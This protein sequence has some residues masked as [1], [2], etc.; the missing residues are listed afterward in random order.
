MALREVLRDARAEG[1]RFVEITTGPDNVAS[2]RVIESNG[3]VLVEEFVTPIALGGKR[4]LR[5]R[6]HTLDGASESS[7]VRT[8]RAI[9]QADYEQVRQLLADM[10]WQQRVEDEGRFERMMRGANR[11]VV[12]VENERVVGFARALFD[13]ASNGYISTVAVAAD[14]RRQGVGRELVKRLMDVDRPADI[15][16]V[17]RARRGSPAFW[18]KMGFTKSE[19]AMEIVRKG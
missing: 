17:L 18:E 14:R 7:M 12:A 1:L 6:V 10:G 4:E 2:R 5:Y 16:W 9:E 13:G 11:T 15:T 3:G 19:V 8:F